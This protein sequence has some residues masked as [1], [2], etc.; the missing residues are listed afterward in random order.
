MQPYF[1]P[2]IG[3]FSLIKNTDRFVVFD[4]IQY[5]HKGWIARNR[6]LK[7]DNNWQYIN[8]PLRKHHRETLISEI[9]I[10]NTED[11]KGKILRQ[12]E[13]YKKIAPYY[14]DVI[15]LLNNCLK[16]DFN[17]IVDLNI[18]ALSDVCKYIGIDF[19]YSISSELDIKWDKINDADEW[20]LEISKAHSSASLILSHFIS[21][22]E[23]IE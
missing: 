3:Y 8:V 6:I 4:N 11:W 7:P 23:E 10:N 22:S 17:Y 18:N 21:N 15:G 14:E 2:Y 13:H 12:L 5:I 1:F 16:K 20:A 19:N 9:E